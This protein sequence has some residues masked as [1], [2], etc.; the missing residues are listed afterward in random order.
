MLQFRNLHYTL[1]DNKIKLNQLDGFT[2]LDSGFVQV[3]V[4]GENKDS[5]LGAKMYRSSE[6]G[7][8]TYK[9]HELSGNTLTVVQESSNVRAE[10]TFETY[11]DT[12]A[13]RIQTKVTNI[14]QEAI[15]LEEVSAFCV[16]G[17]GEKQ[18]PDDMF[19]TNFLQSH[20]AECQPRTK[21]FRELG[22]CGGI[23]ESQ[24]RV[25]GCS[26][27]AGLPRSSCLWVFWRTGKPAISSCSR[28][29]ATAPGTMKFPIR[30][31]DIICT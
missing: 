27:V 19:F 26:L 9:S 7:R 5:H 8:L 24:Q 30:W 2:D 22:L 31:I 29:R 21:D 11:D 17:L 15:V 28:S 25:V 4:A 10:T 18:E 12:N 16:S 20:H 1:I 14:T 23:T 13:I 3:Q 6:A